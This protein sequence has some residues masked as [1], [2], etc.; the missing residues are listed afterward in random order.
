VTCQHNLAETLVTQSILTFLTGAIGSG[1]LFVNLLSLLQRS[2][3]AE[4]IGRASG[5]F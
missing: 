4:M 5:V 3:R 1:F 2:V